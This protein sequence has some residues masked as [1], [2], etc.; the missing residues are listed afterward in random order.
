MAYDTTLD[1]SLELRQR[2]LAPEADELPICLTR[3]NLSSKYFPQCSRTVVSAVAVLCLAF[4]L[5]SMNR[6][7]HTDSWGHLNFGRWIVTQGG[8]PHGDPF[9]AWPGDRAAF[10]NLPWLAQ[11]CGYLTWSTLG[12]EGLVLM[13]ALMATAACGALLAAIRFRGVSL[14]WAVA[15]A[16][17]MYVL[18]LPVTGTLRPQL[19]GMVGVPL[20]LLACACLPKQRWTLLWLPI[21]YLVWANMHGSF[22]IGLAML[23]LYAAGE[24]IDACREKKSL[25]AAWTDSSCRTWALALALAIAASAVNPIGPAIFPAVASFGGSQPLEN[26]TEWRPMV[27]KSFSGMLFFGSLAAGA[28]LLR[29]SPRRISAAE[30]MLALFFAVLTLTSIRMLA[31]WAILFPLLA[32][33]HAAAVW[34]MINERWRLSNPWSAAEPSPH[35]G[36]MNTLIAMVLVFTA[37]IMAPPSHNLLIGQPRGIGEVTM[38]DTPIYVADEIATRQLKGRFFAPMD[39]S[40]YIVWTGGEQLKPLAYTHVH[41]IAQPVWNDYLAISRGEDWLPRARRYGLDYMVVS[42]D[43]QRPLWLKLIE[44]DRNPASPAVILYRDE[45]CLLVKINPPVG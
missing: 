26:I 38:S 43:R 19:I 1:Q 15:G 45:K 2:N 24:V 21:L 17:L 9:A 32:A 22:A 30:A 10:L 36:S 5:T 27:L 41:L 14:G 4:V 34:T 6:I 18:A 20:T 39:W 3:D 35:S 29:L 40:D 28:V 7:N 42:K 23:G 44:A 37:A 8:L 16:A 13:H 31:W 25:A 12:E 11:V 33:P